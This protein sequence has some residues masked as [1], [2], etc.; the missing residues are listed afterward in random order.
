[1]WGGWRGLRPPKNAPRTPKRTCSGF[2]VPNLFGIAHSAAQQLLKNQKRSQRFGTQRVCSDHN[3]T[4]C[5]GYLQQCY[6]SQWFWRAATGSGSGPAAGEYNPTNCSGSGFM[7]QAA[8]ESPG[9]NF[10]AAKD[11]GPGVC[12]RG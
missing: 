4:N 2:G 10:R 11:S 12:S 3:P 7:I 1:M 8:R 5:S 6:C 9:C